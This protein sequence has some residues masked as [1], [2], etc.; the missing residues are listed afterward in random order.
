MPLQ[1]HMQ[2]VRRF[3]E[4]LLRVSPC[5]RGVGQGPRIVSGKDHAAVPLPI[6][7]LAFPNKVDG[8]T[9]VPSSIVVRGRIDAGGHATVWVAHTF[10]LTS[11]SAVH[12][13]LP[14]RR[15]AR[16]PG[17]RAG[18]LY[19]PRATVEYR[20]AVYSNGQNCDIH[21]KPSTSSDWIRLGAVQE[22]VDETSQPWI[23][24]DVVGFLQNDDEDHVDIVEDKG[25]P[26]ALPAPEATPSLHALEEKHD[27]D[28]TYR[29][30]FEP[31]AS[32]RATVVW[33]LHNRAPDH[34]A[35][36]IPAM[37]SGQDACQLQVHIA[38]EGRESIHQGVS[39]PVDVPQLRR[40]LQLPRVQAGPHVLWH[41]A[42]LD[43]Y[44]GISEKVPTIPTA[45]IHAQLKDE[46]YDT[47]Q[48]HALTPTRSHQNLGMGRMG[49]SS[50]F[51]WSLRARGG[52]VVRTELHARYA[53][54][55]PRPCCC[56]RLPEPARLTLT[57]HCFRE[58]EGDRLLL[59]HG[60]L[61]GA[62]W[63]PKN[64]TIVR[65]STR[66]PE[67]WYSYEDAY[68][69]MDLVPQAA[70]LILWV[71][72][73][74]DEL[75]PVIDWVPDT[76]T[77]RDLRAEDNEWEC[78]AI[79]CCARV[80]G[81]AQECITARDQQNKMAAQL[82]GAATGGV[83]PAL[84][85]YSMRSMDKP[86]RA[87]AHQLALQWRLGRMRACT[88]DIPLL[89]RV[90]QCIARM[91]GIELSPG[92]VTHGPVPSSIQR[93]RNHPPPTPFHRD[94]EIPYT[95]ILSPEFATVGAQGNCALAQVRAHPYAQHLGARRQELRDA[96]TQEMIDV[97]AG[98]QVEASDDEEIDEITRI[99][100]WLT[101]TYGRAEG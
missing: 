7:A 3:R 77:P 78:T 84:M 10:S 91:S 9:L 13:F 89:A 24:A 37:C 8:T 92:D 69:C 100:S 54:P 52:A 70:P 56:L 22:L 28:D 63:Q 96:L 81:M 73:V 43:A 98:V 75:V 46:L 64:D 68:E 26:A 51:A 95:G 59:R 25:S 79:P 21:S 18:V 60:R 23:C 32:S 41:H 80:S 88:S 12:Y 99:Q 44:C 11:P 50:C 40:R 6:G 29:F 85:M 87:L 76:W 45:T 31:R 4:N 42:P 83:M 34:L 94:K 5:H 14:R 82:L 97:E 86:W 66:A 62:T 33:T 72:H 30:C 49:E 38:V 48:V 35:V 1:E 61:L 27:K 67:E 101:Q 47:M 90:L 55:P 19:P 74:N 16:P 58:K 2:K 17:Y 36:L 65:G 53:L 71:V 20:G 15:V 39:A 93:E 57:Q